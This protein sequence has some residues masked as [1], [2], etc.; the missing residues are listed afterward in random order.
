MLFHTLKQFIASG[1]GFSVNLDKQFSIRRDRYLLCYHRILSAHKAEDDGVHHSLWLTPEGLSS[2]IRWMKS[3]GAIVDY[4]RIT[5]TSIPNDRPLFALTFDDGWKDN[6]EYALPVLK[7]YQVPAHIFLSTEAVDTGALFWPQDI[8]T[9]TKRLVA[10]GHA[11]KVFSAL[12]E[13]MPE[14]AMS[15]IPKRTEVM[16]IVESWIE[17][18]KL[19]NDNDR[20][21]LI[22]EYYRR[23]KLKI[24]PLQ[25]YLL[26]WDDA[27]IMQKNGISFGSHTHNHTIIEG[28]PPEMIEYE[29]NRSKSLIA[30]KLQINVDSFCY[31]NGRYNGKERSILSRCGYR[32]AFR[33]DNMSLQHCTDNLYI[34]RFL[35]SERKSA[36]P[37]YLKLCLLEAPL[38]RSKPHKPCLEDT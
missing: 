34:P 15:A 4:S 23:L 3:V 33:L 38:Y 7:Q 13:F 22:H 9:K 19:Q 11:E 2:Q 18:L 16:E 35:I 12:V 8:A 31:P 30:D 10:T 1:L 25:G 28:L 14:Q 5:D 21:K 17:S 29:I 36:N 27:R 20:L 26:C 24:D 32:Y 6:F 37:A